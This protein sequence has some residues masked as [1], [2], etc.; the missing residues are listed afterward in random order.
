MEFC[1]YELDGIGFGTGLTFARIT[2]FTSYFACGHFFT[3]LMVK[4]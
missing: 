1:R 3:A 4:E 2:G